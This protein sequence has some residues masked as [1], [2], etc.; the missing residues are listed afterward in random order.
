MAI[1]YIHE[2]AIQFIRRSLVWR[3]RQDLS[4]RCRLPVRD[5][6]AAAF[7][8]I[9]MGDVAEVGGWGGLGGEEGKRHR[10]ARDIV[11]VWA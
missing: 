8:N 9:K 6:E 3:E 11:R 4:P 2:L 7:G 1:V 5:R 10:R